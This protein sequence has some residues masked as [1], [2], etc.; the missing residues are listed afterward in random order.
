MA[1][2]TTRAGKGSPLTNTEVDDNFSNLNSA[3]YES[4]STPT[5]GNVAAGAEL[6]L[7][8]ASSLLGSNDTGLN[9]YSNN[10]LYVA[11]GSAGLIL[12]GQGL[13]PEYVR[14]ASETVFNEDSL[15]RD[16]RVESNDNTHALFVD[17]NTNRVGLFTSSPAAP[18][19]IQFGDNTNIF[20]GSY[21]SGEDNFFLELDSKIVTGGVVGYQF[22]LKNN[23][24]AY[25]NTL[26]LDRGNVGIGV[27]SA[28]YKLDI[29][30]S[31]T[32]VA[33]VLATGNNT[34]ALGYYQA[35]T[36][37]GDDINMVLGVF[38]DANRGELST[39]T[40]H[41]LRL[42]VNNTPSKYLEIA[43]TGQIFTSHGMVVNEDSN[44]SD[45]RVE[46]NNKGHLLFVDASA[47][48]IGIN[49]SSPSHL[50]TVKSDHAT[51][52]AIKIE[53][54]G[55]TD[56]WGFAANNNEGRLE[57]SRIGGGVAGTH[58][59][60]TN[61]GKAILGDVESKTDDLLQIETPASGGG[62]GIQ[63]RRN[64]SNNDQGIGHIKF[65]NNTDT[66]L[67]KLA[68]GTDG[69]VDAGYLIL[70]TQPTGGSLTDRLI[71]HSQG[72]VV[73]NES[74][75]GADFRVESSNVS[76]MLT[77]DADQDRVGVGTSGGGGALNVLRDAPTS[78]SA[79]FQNSHASGYGQSWNSY[80]GHQVFMYHEGDYKASITTASNSVTYS[81]SSSADLHLQAGG[82]REV[83]VNDSGAATN[84]R[85]ESDNKS[86]LFYI[87]ASND[88]VGIGD[89][90]TLANGLRIASTTSTTDDVDAKL[91]L[92]AISSGTTTTG[93]GPGIVFAGARNGDGA[94]QQMARINAVAEVNSGT[95]LSSGL[96]FMT[97][98]AGVNSTK[99]TINNL[100]DVGLGVTPDTFS[101]GYT[102]LQING[103]AYNIGHSGGDHYITNNAYFNSGWKYGKTGTAQM[104]E[105]SS[106]QI[107]FK[108]VNSGSADSAITW[109]RSMNVLDG[110][111]VVVNDDSADIDFRVESNNNAY[112]LRV[113]GGND[114]LGIKTHA[115]QDDVHIS[116]ATGSGLMLTRVTGANSGQ[117]G[118]IRFGS[119]DYDSNL[120]NIGAH[121]DGSKTSAYLSFETQKTGA[122]TAERMRIQSDGAVVLKPS[123]ITTG[124]RL[125]G[126]SSD[127][128]F[129]I[130][131][132]NYAGDTTHASI[133]T[134]SAN[135]TLL[136]NADE[137][138]FNSTSSATN[139]LKIKDNG[140]LI[141]RVDGKTHFRVSDDFTATGSSVTKFAINLNTLLGASTSGSL[142]YTVRV[143]G[144]GS[145]G[146]NAI[147]FTYSVGGYS[148][149]NY[150]ATNYASLGAG[151]IDNGYTSSGSSETNA[152]G[153]SYHPARNLGA[154]IANGR[155]FVYVPGPQQYGVTVQNDSSQSFG[156]TVEIT[157]YY[158]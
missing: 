30:G 67:A 24:T 85:V 65:G 38:G 34:R 32:T 134:D 95:N 115:P 91:Y 154:Y 107:Q 143:M 19:D 86:H 120:A 10:Y 81:T 22:H 72:S 74:G 114:R 84:F 127:N 96:Q 92:Q 80:S 102:A 28:G 156:V 61:T 4:G 41:T 93:F 73:F 56:G 121:Q 117:L 112:M 100:G 158:S 5:F 157:G 45:F 49:D 150:S 140:V 113:D 42:Y 155:V 151:T 122:A 17:A 68:A 106:G 153:L 60:I 44:D 11:G 29:Q 69:A 132:K 26:T 53:Q 89:G 118:N 98:T 59:T 97:A 78:F 129:Y 128:N 8:A 139:Y 6:T 119:E 43:T 141:N 76:N 87:D 14:F 21:A 152:A 70:A 123:G 109:V 25:N 46:S 55:N 138:E 31:A 108:T 94:N 50:L 7:T 79:T 83:T 35:H 3:K 54:T 125:Q 37:G 36:S 135:N 148:G 20:R 82:T 101:S 62:H 99:M 116:A 39:G 88:G 75:V 124:L 133:G 110:G 48:K 2:I 145:G 146:S 27:E 52:P 64:D 142:H 66:D 147:N 16:F 77:I 105:L 1:T 130:Q 144:Y 71:I 57:F 131:Y 9:H 12:K 13:T 136:Y 63:I 15:A 126:R 111:G 47:D 137:H 18:L 90:H 51:N 58:F 33:R 40:N 23:G 149:H 103:Y 104:V